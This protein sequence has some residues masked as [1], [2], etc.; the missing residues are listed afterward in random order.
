ML[1]QAGGMLQPKSAVAGGASPYGSDSRV[2]TTLSE[3]EHA[4]APSG[5]QG[6]AGSNHPPREPR[7]SLVQAMTTQH[8]E[9]GDLSRLGGRLIPSET[10]LPPHWAFTSSSSA[11]ADPREFLS[12]R[13][14]AIPGVTEPQTAAVA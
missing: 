12:P 13:Q 2:G 8:L 6:G 4:A 10:S 14:V 5:I 1:S 3:V 11:V 7:L 9:T